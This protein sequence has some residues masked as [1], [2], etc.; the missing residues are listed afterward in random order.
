MRILEYCIPSA[1]PEIQVQIITLRQAFSQDTS[2]PFELKPSLGLRSPTETKPSPS[3]DHNQYH[4]PPIHVAPTWSHLQED[5][6]SHTIS[7][8]S[9]YGHPLDRQAHANSTVPFQQPSFNTLTHT[10]YGSVSTHQVSSGPNTAYSFE[11]PIGHE[12]TTPTWDPSIMFNQWNTAFG[13]PQAAPPLLHDQP[14]Q[15]PTVQMIPQQYTA[16]PQPIVSP[17][18]HLAASSMPSLQQ[19]GSEMP[20]VTP[21]MWQEAFTNAYVSGQ[22]YKRYREESLEPNPFHQ[23]H[24]RRG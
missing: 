14:V 13:Q 12:N 17:L 21:V 10:P 16:A 24:K 8:A 7:P 19:V 1:S 9:E 15:P 20:T 6:S 5:A 11:H 4:I 3:F 2:K 18:H 23:Y 22:G